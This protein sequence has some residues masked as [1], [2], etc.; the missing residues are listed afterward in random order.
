MFDRIDRINRMCA[1]DDVV[2]VG[3]A[4]QA[5][6]ASPFIALHTLPVL[7]VGSLLQRPLC[8]QRGKI[9]LDRIDKIFWLWFL[10]PLIV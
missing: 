10:N 4:K 6:F 3:M 7:R 5:R 1:Q 9:P 2:G 8:D